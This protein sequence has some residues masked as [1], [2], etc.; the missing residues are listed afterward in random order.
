MH[1]FVYTSL[2]IKTTVQLLLP[3]QCR[4]MWL[5]NSDCVGSLQQRGGTWLHNPCCVQPFHS[6]ML[7]PSGRTKARKT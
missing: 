2:M 3:I 6:R 5:Q 7:H 4:V 1:P